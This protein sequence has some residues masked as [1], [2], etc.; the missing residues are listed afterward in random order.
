MRLLNVRASG[1]VGTFRNRHTVRRLPA[2]L[3]EQRREAL[4]AAERAE[5]ETEH[6]V[7]TR[8]AHLTDAERRSRREKANRIHRAAVAA[9]MIER[10]GEESRRLA[11]R[12]AANARVHVERTWAAEDDFAMLTET[13]GDVRPGNIAEARK[14]RR[15]AEW[16]AAACAGRCQLCD[17]ELHGEDECELVKSLKTP[18]ENDPST[19]WRRG[20]IDHRPPPPAVAAVRSRSGDEPIGSGQVDSNDLRGGEGGDDRVSVD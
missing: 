2:S 17:G 11:M 5:A 3:A 6:R 15:Y 8:G 16:Q 13:P 4:A 20:L 1:N 14:S 10:Y 9:N 12:R 19:A 7:V 18:Q